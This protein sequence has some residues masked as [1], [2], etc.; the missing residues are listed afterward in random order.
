MIS[1]EPIKTSYHVT[2]Q[3]SN[4]SS[5]KRDLKLRLPEFQTFFLN[6]NSIVQSDELIKLIL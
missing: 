6:R 1:K 4:N 2:Y 5:L 3:N